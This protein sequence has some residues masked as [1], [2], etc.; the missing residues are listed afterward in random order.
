[1]I[2]LLVAGVF[3]LVMGFGMGWYIANF[4]RGQNLA[5]ELKKAFTLKPD[6]VL[7][8][9]YSDD[10]FTLTKATIKTGS[11]GEKNIVID[12]KENLAVL[13]P[14][15]FSYLHIK[16]KAFSVKVPFVMYYYGMPVRIDLLEILERGDIEGVKDY[17]KKFIEI[18]GWEKAVFLYKSAKLKGFE[19]AIDKVLSKLPSWLPYV[20]IGGF[21]AGVVLIL[22]GGLFAFDNISKANA[23]ANMYSK[24]LG[25]CYMQLL[26]NNIKPHPFIENIVAPKK[27]EKK[28]STAKKVVSQMIT[29][30]K[31]NT[32]NTNK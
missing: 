22:G 16:F 18:A 15:A 6:E 7:L 14:K 19:E 25:L 23:Q 29:I 28:E 31:Q 3:C 24:A 8:L 27:E 20:S 21:I 1:M 5:E 13:D 4:L 17:I 9:K 11:S 10:G 2:E 30:Q 26:D 12:E 32:K